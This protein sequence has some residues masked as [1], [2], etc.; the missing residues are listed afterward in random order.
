MAPGKGY[1]PQDDAADAE[2]EEE[3]DD[4]TDSSS[5]EWLEVKSEEEVEQEEEADEVETGFLNCLKEYAP[6]LWKVSG[7][8]QNFWKVSIQPCGRKTSF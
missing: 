8:L 5:E 3:Q 6:Q 1:Q 7:P 2:K 4:A